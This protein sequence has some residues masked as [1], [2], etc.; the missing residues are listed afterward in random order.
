MVLYKIALLKYFIAYLLLYIY[1]YLPRKIVYICLLK[2]AIIY[3]VSPS[4]KI[5]VISIVNG[6]SRKLKNTNGIHMYLTNFLNQRSIN[7]TFVTPVKAASGQEA[8]L[9]LIK[10]TFTR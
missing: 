6:G 8:D 10:Q 4:F 1:W 7:R 5:I 9:T 3:F 2:N